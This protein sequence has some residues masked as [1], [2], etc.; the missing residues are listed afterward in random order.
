MPAFAY[1]AR[2]L[3]GSTTEGT[4]DAA[5]QRAA[6]DELRKQKLIPIEVNESSRA[7]GEILAGINPFKPK[8]KSKELVLFS[9]QLSTLVSAGVPLV[10][11]LSILE[12]QVE[13]LLFKSIVHQI[14]ED[15]EAG[16]SIT[17]A[18]RKHPC[19]LFQ[20][21]A[22]SSHL[23]SHRRFDNEHFELSRAWWFRGLTSKTF[24]PKV[25]TR[26]VNTRKTWASS[27]YAVKLSI[28]G[29]LV[30]VD[31]FVSRGT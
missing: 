27:W 12:E 31:R 10:Q 18:L 25:A 24:L 19:S 22:W 7:L 6:M 15:I 1:K 11:G 21:R 14:R 20:K 17:D 8:V 26:V 16:Q 28:F 30:K 4:I 9:R 3:S 23:I 13:S 5:D 2:M 29:R